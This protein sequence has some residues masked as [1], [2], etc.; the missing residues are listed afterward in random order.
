MR[1]VGL[2]RRIAIAKLPVSGRQTT[3]GPKPAALHPEL[4]VA[5]AISEDY[6]PD[7]H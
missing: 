2:A 1:L 5:G 3:A 7:G 6:R 4:A